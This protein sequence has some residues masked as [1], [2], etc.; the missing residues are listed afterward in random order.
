VAL[1]L[2]ARA[3][4]AASS[5]VAA[6]SAGNAGCSTTVSAVQSMNDC[7]REMTLWTLANIEYALYIEYALSSIR[8][9]EI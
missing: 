4:S 8:V 7:P 2:L 5:R 3:K 6:S 1:A 9:L